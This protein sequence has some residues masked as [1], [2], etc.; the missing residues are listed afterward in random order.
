MSISF[1]I[2]RALF[3]NRE[4]DFSTIKE[5]KAAEIFNSCAVA[6]AVLAPIKTLQQ[7]E[8]EWID[9]PILDKRFSSVEPASCSPICGILQQS[10]HS[11]VIAEDAVCHPLRDGRRISRSLIGLDRFL[12]SFET[13]WCAVPFLHGPKCSDHVLDR[14]NVTRE[15]AVR[16][17]SSRE[18]GLSEH[19][20]N[21]E[22][23]AE[24]CDETCN[25]RLVSVQ[26]VFAAR[27]CSSV[28]QR[29]SY[30]ILAACV[31]KPCQYVN[32]TGGH[33]GRDHEMKA[34]FPH[35]DSFARWNSSVE[36]A[37]A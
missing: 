26:P 20:A 6:Q 36:R 3:S 15:P 24:E 27:G 5:R 37:E 34:L 9:E 16:I 32:G 35:W 13:S 18:A 29:F 8:A 25:E 31:D 14:G 33:G 19:G 4:Q 1:K 28:G 17:I 7:C 23:S 10:E 2:G 22:P 21:R 12:A 30:D 11:I